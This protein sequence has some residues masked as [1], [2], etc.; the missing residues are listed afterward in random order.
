[1]SFN[2]KNIKKAQIDPGVDFG[3]NTGS[4]PLTAVDPAVQPQV[5][6]QAVPSEPPMQKELEHGKV[7]DI[8]GLFAVLSDRTKDNIRMQYKSDEDLSNFLDSVDPV[9]AR[10]KLFEMADMENE[11]DLSEIK[12]FIE[13]YYDDEGRMEDKGIYPAKQV[14]SCVNEV[15]E[16]IKKAAQK[17]A[18]ENNTFNLKTAQAKSLS[19][20]MM[21]GPESTRFDTVSRLPVSDWHVIERNKGF[22]GFF[23]DVFNFDW[24]AFWRG[25]IMDKYSRPYRDKDGNWVGGYIQKRFEVDKWIPEQ[26]NYQLKP[27]QRRKP[28]LPEYGVLEARMENMRSKPEYQEEHSPS[29]PGTP[30]DWKKASTIEK[31]LKTSGVATDIVELSARF[32]IRGMDDISNSL[33]SVAKSMISEIKTAILKSHSV[34]ISKDS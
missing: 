25:N 4:T 8:T 19:N 3:Q 7:D 11:K 10:Q 2:L 24:E 5:Q 33:N 15:Y 31:T 26:N 22:G 27:G 32:K 6:P 13:M 23:G 18:K 28:Y 16:L 9:M 14:E 34:S 29:T 21:F 1:M 30:F 20:V 12:N 17:S